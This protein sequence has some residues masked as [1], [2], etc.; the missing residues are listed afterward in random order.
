MKARRQFVSFAW[1]QGA[2]AAG[3]ILAAGIAVWAGT[4]AQASVD[5]KSKAVLARYFK[6]TDECA[7]VAKLRL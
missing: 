3:A 7:Q 2:R 1:K 5:G 4:S 6:V